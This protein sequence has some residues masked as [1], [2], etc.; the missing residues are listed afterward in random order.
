MTIKS[1]YRLYYTTYI[2]FGIAMF[3]SAV[4]ELAVSIGLK[5]YF[6]TLG[7]PFYFTYYLAICKAM[8][9]AGMIYF[10][11][12]HLKDW[13]YSGFF[14]VLLSAFISTVASGSA[15]VNTIP[16]LILFAVLAGNYYSFHKLEERKQRDRQLMRMTHKKHISN[17]ISIE[18]KNLYNDAS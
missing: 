17:D 6:T 12:R 9:L 18:W 4:A 15:L 10:K 8:G 3:S 1:I 16:P 7:Y 2:A 13:I 11:N 14:I 5:S